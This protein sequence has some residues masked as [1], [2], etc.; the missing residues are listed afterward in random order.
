MNN[1]KC[2]VS[3]CTATRFASVAV[4]NI[5]ANLGEKVVF[6]IQCED[7][8]LIAPDTTVLSSELKSSIQHQNQLLIQLIEELK[9][10]R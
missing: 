9:S 4:E 7:G 1:P 10:R 5:N 8:H 2:P 6:M 3:G